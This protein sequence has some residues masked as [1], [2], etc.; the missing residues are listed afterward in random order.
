MMSADKTHVCQIHADRERVDD[1]NDGIR[2][3]GKDVFGPMRSSF[4]KTMSR[5]SAREGAR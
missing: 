3:T 2:G 4:P 5:F 1:K